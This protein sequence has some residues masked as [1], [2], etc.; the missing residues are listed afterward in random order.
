MADLAYYVDGFVAQRH[1]ER[2]RAVG[3]T[4]S[5]TVVSEVGRHGGTAEV[6]AE[7]AKR[8]GANLILIGR[9][10]HGALMR[11]I[12][13]SV[14]TGVFRDAPCSLLVVRDVTS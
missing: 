3:V 6:I 5:A 11:L 9:S 2:L 13:G 14:T 4:A 8:H 1:A 7:Q 10:H 12:G